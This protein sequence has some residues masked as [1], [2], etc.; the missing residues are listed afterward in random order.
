MYGPCIESQ[1][2]QRID[3]PSLVMHG[4]NAPLLNNLDLA[5]H[6]ILHPRLVPTQVSAIGLAYTCLQYVQ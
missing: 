4:H 3:S 5:A 1:L 6:E 2:L